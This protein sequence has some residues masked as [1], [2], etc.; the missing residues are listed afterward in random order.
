MNSEYMF[1][2]PVDYKI[3]ESEPSLLAGA[4]VIDDKNKLHI[5]CDAAYTKTNINSHSSSNALR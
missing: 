4:C 2:S 5:L 1:F 3:R